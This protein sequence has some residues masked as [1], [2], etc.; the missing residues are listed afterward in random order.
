MNNKLSKYN[1]ADSGSNSQ[2]RWQAL[3]WVKSTL[4]SYT[5]YLPSFTPSVWHPLRG[6]LRDWPLALCDASSVN[7]EKDS[8]AGNLIDRE[9][10]SENIQIQ[11]SPQQKWYYLRDQSP[12]ELLI[13]KNADSNSPSGATPGEWRIPCQELS[14][15]IGKGL[16]CVWL[17]GVPHSSFVNPNS[18][19]SDL[20]RES[21]ECRLLVLW[22]T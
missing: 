12:A 1:K 9:G 19:P 14:L 21:I 18:T 6:P 20:L 3:K 16:I 15:E 4:I 8:K 11:Y 13:F 2:L 22:E 7:F 10:G 17:L 5:L